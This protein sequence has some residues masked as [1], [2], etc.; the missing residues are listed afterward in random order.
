MK[1]LKQ[2]IMKGIMPLALAGIA[3]LSNGCATAPVPK[4]YPDKIIGNYAMGKNAYE[5]LTRYAKECEGNTDESTLEEIAGKM[6]RNE[7]NFISE[8]EAGYQCRWKGVDTYLD[9]D[10]YSS[11]E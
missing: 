9:T 6:D 11:R 2:K 3:A 7:D 5:L 4:E 10:V 8:G 1:N